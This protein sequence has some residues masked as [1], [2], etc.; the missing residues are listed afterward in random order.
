MVKKN[1]I[2]V[3]T[4]TEY[5]INTDFVIKREMPEQ[6]FL[7]LLPSDTE[8]FY[9]WKLICCH[10]K[11]TRNSTYLGSSLNA[12]LLFHCFLRVVIQTDS[13]ID[14]L[15]YPFFEPVKTLCSV[16]LPLT[17]ADSWW[18]HHCRTG[19]LAAPAWCAGQSEEGALA[20]SERSCWN[21]PQ[22]LK[23]GR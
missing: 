11:R 7:L 5:T 20:R 3:K 13:I 18:H 8:Y 17:P 16:P 2:S 12:N 15:E 10:Q 19:R 1:T 23:A 9:E 21:E 14:S 22:D 4:T 6:G